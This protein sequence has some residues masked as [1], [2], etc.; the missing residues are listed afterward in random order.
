[1]EDKIFRADAKTIVDMAFNNKLFKE[2]L[3]RDDFNAFE[4]LIHF[5]LQSRFDS[6]V[7]ITDLMD[8]IEKRKEVN[9]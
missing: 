4:D 6:Y 3:T 9:P 1:M 7:R 2:E 8:K 5:L